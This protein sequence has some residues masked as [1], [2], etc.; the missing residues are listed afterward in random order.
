MLLSFFL[1]PCSL[2]GKHIAARQ[3]FVPEPIR[4]GDPPVVLVCLGRPT[5]YLRK[6]ERNEGR[7]TKTEMKK[8]RKGGRK[9]GRGRRGGRRRRGRRGGEE[10]REK[11]GEE[12]GERKTSSRVHQQQAAIH[13]AY[14]TPRSTQGK[15]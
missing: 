2:E 4:H 6:K 13:T 1:S 9:E 3:S 10:D 7:T 5:G 14:R 8:E 11:E 12:G 15:A